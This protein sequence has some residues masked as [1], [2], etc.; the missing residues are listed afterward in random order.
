VNESF[1]CEYAWRASTNPSVDSGVVIEVDDGI[2]ARIT[3][4]IATPPPGATVLRG[5]TFPGLANAHSHSFHR[6]L[7]SRIEGR[8]GA[9]TTF[10]DWRDQMYEVA[11]TIDPERFHRLARATFAEMALAGITLVGEFHYLHH[12]ADGGRYSDINIMGEAVGAAAAEAGVRLT[13]LDTCYLHGGLGRHGYTGANAVQRR[14]VDSDADAWAT[15]VSELGSSDL[16]RVGAAVHSVRAVDPGSIA[17]VARWAADQDLPLHAHVSEQPEENVQCVSTHRMTPA[18]LLAAAGAVNS[19]FTAVHGTHLNNED[20]EILGGGGATVCL[21][22]TTE[23]DLADGTGAATAMVEAGVALA[24]GSDSQSV[25]DLFEESRAIELDER[26]SSLRRGLHSPTA[27]LEAASGGGYRSLGWD[28]GGR[29]DPGALADFTTLKT[30]SPRLAGLPV[31][32]LVAGAV[33]AAT[34]SDVA[35]VV[36]AGETIVADGRHRRLDVTAELSKALS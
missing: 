27:L 23:R 33:F 5:F 29:L 11:A 22:P 4:G 8:G 24:V 10:W 34:A 3:S 32:D 31:S 36:V 18:A 28:G 25:I 1:W 9:P 26:L 12:D 13:L 7:R 6:A 20:L 17:T 21:C 30:D 16:M 14:F 35:N 19:R 2:I 15:R